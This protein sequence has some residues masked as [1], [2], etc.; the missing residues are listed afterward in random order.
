LKRMYMYNTSY[1]R[2]AVGRKETEQMTPQTT[3]DDL[4]WHELLAKDFS[5]ACGTVDGRPHKSAR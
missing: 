3:W 5:C 4:W 1:A 2:E